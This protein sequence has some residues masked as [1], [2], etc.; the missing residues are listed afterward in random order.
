MK[1]LDRNTE[2][3]LLRI[4][5]GSPVATFVINR[6][7]KVIHWNKA[8]EALTGVKRSEVIGTSEHRKA[9]YNTAKDILADLIIDGASEAEIIERYDGKAKKSQLIEGAFESEDYFPNLSGDNGSWL[10]FTASPIKGDDYSLIGAIETLENITERKNAENSLIASEGNYRNLFESAM[11]AIWVT[12]INGNIQRVNQSTTRL[13]GYTI[14]ELKE[15]NIDLFITGPSLV[16]AKE[17]RQS[18]LQGHP[19]NGA[20]NQTVVRKDNTQADCM[21]TT[22][23]ISSSSILFL[24]VARDITEAKKQFD[25]QQNYLKEI[26]RAQAEERKRVARELHDSTAQNL[27]AL[28][29]Q[30]ENLLDD[31]STIPLSQ[32]KNLWSI[33]E[34]IRDI[35][36]EVRRFSRD[37]R[38]AIL[39]DLEL[40]PAL[41]WL[42]TELKTN[43]GIETALEKT[44]EERRLTPETELL[45]FRIV[46]ESLTNVVKHAQASGVTVKVEFGGNKLS[47][48]VADNGAGF[49][50]PQHIGSL[51]QTGKLG[52][53]GIE[54]RVQLLG[55]K[56][57]ISSA[58]GQGTTLKIETAI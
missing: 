28:L 32:A 22:N 45:I 50:P 51:V 57:S 30:L 37:L 39:D 49:D 19:L 21:V 7:H 38:P 43:Y 42:T 5:D 52:L 26:T 18:L 35:L 23:I 41:E 17:V 36:Q 24:N 33:Y 16:K 53:P 34:R 47:V 13:T 1:E 48:T 54:E 31:K 56:L 46:Q 6:Q 12:D 44:G 29:H 14:A 20:Y 2:P 40:M 11:D 3:A 25:N 27:I 9:F 4:M 55:G 8:I 10:H 15:N 58:P